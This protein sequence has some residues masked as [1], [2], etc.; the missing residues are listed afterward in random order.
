M[1]REV[2][3]HDDNDIVMLGDKLP[4]SMKLVQSMYNELT[5]KTENIGQMLNG[6]HEITFSDIQQLN[7]KILQLFEQYSVIE[8]SCCVTIYHINDSKEQFSSFDRF[9]FYEKG[10]KSPCENIRIEYNFLIVLPATK[11][12]QSYKIT[13]DL[14]SRAAL[15]RKAR[16]EV[17]VN[18]RIVQM[19]AFRTGM[20]DIEYVDYT[21][22]RNF[23]T[24]INEWYG[25]VNKNEGFWG[26]DT[27]QDNSHK[28]S[29][30]FSVLSLF[31]LF[32]VIYFNSEQLVPP[33]AS[34]HQLYLAMV[35]SIFSAIFISVVAG[36]FGSACESLIDVYAPVSGLILNK[37]DDDVLS[38]QRRSNV[39]TVVG[40]ILFTAITVGLNVFSSYAFLKMGITG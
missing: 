19:V 35:V 17:G 4:V 23:M 18:R 33:A 1:V 28:I 15:K 2:I 12:P 38:E 37:G 30:V 29:S 39:K 6:N 20:I 13:V 25:S 21:V 16:A 36:R 32:F 3:G 8:K 34:L 22:A 10:S 14:H 5:G 26:Y 31:C 40:G 24:A 9:S 11:K 7:F 27:L